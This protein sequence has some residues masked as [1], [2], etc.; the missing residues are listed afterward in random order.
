M[1]L[2]LAES[3][4]GWMRA[5]RQLHGTHLPL[6][7]IAPL[8]TIAP[9]MTAAATPHTASD[10]SAFALPPYVPVA[11]GATPP[12]L[13]VC[14]CVHAYSSVPRGVHMRACILLCASRCAYACMHT[15][16]CLEV[17]MY[18]GQLRPRL[19]CMHARMHACTHACLHTGSWAGQLQS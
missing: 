10:V 13:E 9:T 17:C 8:S 7:T 14:I 15:P 6:G 1:I 5:A 19:I 16:P 12:C 4:P 3:K 11:A 2:H 18:P